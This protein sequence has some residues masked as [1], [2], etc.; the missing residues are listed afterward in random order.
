MKNLR[1]NY[2]QSKYK[3]MQ[4][5]ARYDS[6]KKMIFMNLSNITLKTKNISY[7]NNLHKFKKVKRMLFQKKRNE[8]SRMKLEET[9]NTKILL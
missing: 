1:T 8:H 3:N 9:V 6:L 5:R 4:E 2:G 7:H